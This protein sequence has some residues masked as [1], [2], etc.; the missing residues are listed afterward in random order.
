[1]LINKNFIMYQSKHFM[2]TGTA[3]WGEV[4]QWPLAICHEANAETRV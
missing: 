1:M 2:G 3:H 4:Y